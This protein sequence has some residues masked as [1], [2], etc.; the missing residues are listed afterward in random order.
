MLQVG[1]EAADRVEIS[2]RSLRDD[3]DDDLLDGPEIAGHVADLEGDDSLPEIQFGVDGNLKAKL[4]GGGG[5]EKSEITEPVAGAGVWLALHVGE[6]TRHVFECVADRR[7][8]ALAEGE[9][10][11]GKVGRRAV[12]PRWVES[13]DAAR[14]HRRRSIA[15]GGATVAEFRRPEEL[16]RRAV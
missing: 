15:D 12:D 14:W 9:L 3:A 7:L 10:L 4:A 5:V 8:S 16:Q 11:D 1:S 2:A 6:A 13:R